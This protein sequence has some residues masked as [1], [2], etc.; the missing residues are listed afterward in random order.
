ME[1]ERFEYLYEL[2]SS[3]IPVRKKLI[4]SVALTGNVHTKEHNTNIPITPDEIADDVQ[5]CFE[6]G[7]RVFHIHATEE[8]GNPC[9]KKETFEEIISK[10]KQNT[11]EAIICVTTSGRNYTK[12][13]ERSDV[14]NIEGEFTKF[15]KKYE[16][17]FSRYDS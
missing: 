12:F 15:S 3:E 9:W 17:K 8:D 14:L 13:E 5:K 2:G 11:P 4:I 10:V 6:A 16:C 7:A 1:P